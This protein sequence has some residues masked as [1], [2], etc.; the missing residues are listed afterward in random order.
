M[1]RQ[2]TVLTSPVTDTAIEHIRRCG[3]VKLR[4]VV[5][6]AGIENSR[7]E[8]R[9]YVMDRRQTLN[10][11]EKSVGASATKNMFRLGDAPQVVSDFVT[12]PL[13]GEIAARLLG[14]EAVRV[15]HFCGFFK[16]GGG[17]PTPWHQD[18]TYIPLD[19]EK[20]LSIWIPLTR[21]T[22]DMG[23]LVFAEGSHLHG[24]LDDEHRV[25]ARYP[26][27]QTG[28]LEVGDVSV[29]M[30]WTLHSSLKNTS[31]QMREAITI[32]FYPDGARIETRGDV[33][34]M[35]CIMNDCFPGLVHGDLAA[36]ASNPLVYKRPGGE[37][38]EANNSLE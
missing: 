32:L 20:V 36:G 21:I 35:Q 25:P 18:L 5:P 17:L 31:T 11:Q 34:F 28:S 13:L 26:L 14:V 16:A 37:G 33:P 1:S 6:P 12:M 7:A 9:D 27:V 3:W 19:T 38:A 2:E 4:G 24:Q 23:V 10:A 15:L 8:I 29:H 30:G 22:T